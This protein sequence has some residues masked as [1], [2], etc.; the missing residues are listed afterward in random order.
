MMT[1]IHQTM[2][3][4]AGLPGWKWVFVIGKYFLWNYF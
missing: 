4:Y 3:G 1:A 2:D